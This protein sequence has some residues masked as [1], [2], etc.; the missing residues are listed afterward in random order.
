MYALQIT[1]QTKLE[2]VA[3]LCKVQQFIL[4]AQKYKLRQLHNQ[5][6]EKELIEEDEDVEEKVSNYQEPACIYNSYVNHIKFSL[7]K[8]LDE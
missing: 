3:H 1:P 6:K 5:I 7:L 4:D 2:V 8:D